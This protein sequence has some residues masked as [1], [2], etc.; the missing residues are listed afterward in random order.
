LLSE[1]CIHYAYACRNAGP[2]QALREDERQPLFVLLGDHDLESERPA[3]VAIDQGGAPQL[4]PGGRE[5]VECAPPLG[6]VTI[7]RGR[8]RTA[9]SCPDPP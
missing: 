7:E 2:L 1:D 4:E 8:L 3:A 6:K 5:Q 9:D